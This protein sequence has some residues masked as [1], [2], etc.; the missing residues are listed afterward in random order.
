MEL[1]PGGLT[2]GPADLRSPPPDGPWEPLE[3]DGRLVGWAAGPVNSKLASSALEMGERIDRERRAHL[4]ARLDHKLRSA[5]LSLQESARGAAYGRPE[6]LESVYDQA[7]EVARRAAAMA[8]VAVDPKEPARAVVLAAALGSPVGVET[9]LP[10][11]AIVFVPEPVLV[12]ALTRATE[13]MGGRGTR[14]SGR[15]SGSWWRLDFEAA[16]ERQALT[17]PELGE[18]LVRL[19]VDHH[20]EGW[21]D[22]TRP[23]R[24]SVFLP[25]VDP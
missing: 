18:P 17:V 8:A 24:A 22:A 15:R 7:Q 21:L 14:I 25:A 23:G 20:L 11:E 13:W 10:D 5:V 19:L 1:V 2:H 9:S 12:E 6:L 3:A 16:P 4:L